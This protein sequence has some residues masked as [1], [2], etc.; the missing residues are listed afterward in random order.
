MLLHWY[1]LYKKNGGSDVI[2]PT[3]NKMS[4]T[5]NELIL[6][7][8]IINSLELNA[9]LDEI[10]QGYLK[11]NNIGW[12]K[13]FDFDTILK[14]YRPQSK[15]IFQYL[16]DNPTIK[17]HELMVGILFKIEENQNEMFH[18]FMKASQKVDVNSYFE[19]GECFYHG[20]GIEK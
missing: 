1:N 18:W 4:D 3:K 13:Y 15:Y 12:T 6:N 8:N 20:Y 2:K 11:N 10:F 19:L 9:A 16:M 7:I 5:S 17:H 14:K